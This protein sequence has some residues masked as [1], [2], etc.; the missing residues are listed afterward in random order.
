MPLLFVAVGSAIGGVARYLVSGALQRGTRGSFPFGT[1]AVNLIGSFILG[2]VVQY[3]LEH[4]DFSPELRLF[5]TAG[6]CGG[7]TTFSTFSVETFDLL[8]YAHYS[9]ALLYVAA[10]LGLGLLATAAGVLL[11]RNVIRA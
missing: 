7:F 1:L 3:A 8:E 6:F 11:A 9:Q 2:F 4:R 10:S 5:L